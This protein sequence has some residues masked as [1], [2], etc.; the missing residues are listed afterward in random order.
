V[1]AEPERQ[2]NLLGE[3]IV[4]HN[5]ATFE[6]GLQTSCVADV[7]TYYTRVKKATFL[8]NV[9]H[10]SC[11]QPKAAACA[12]YNHHTGDHSPRERCKGKDIAFI[13]AEV[14]LSTHDFHIIHDLR[15]VNGRPKSTTY[16][17]I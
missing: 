5:T 13:M 1:V 8:V 15:E 16:D 14:A 6:T 10:P 9:M 7:S 2:F 3:F 12:I 17:I 4:I 11:I